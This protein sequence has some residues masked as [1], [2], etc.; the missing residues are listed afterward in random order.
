MKLSAS[1]IHPYIVANIVI[2]SSP[3]WL[4]IA[5]TTLSS[6]VDDVPSEIF[7]S[8]IRRLPSPHILHHLNRWAK[9]V[10][11]PAVSPQSLAELTRTPNR[12]TFIALGFGA[13]SLLAALVHAIRRCNAAAWRDVIAVMFL[14]AD[15]WTVEIGYESV[16][17]DGDVDRA[18]NTMNF[19]YN[20]NQLL[21]DAVSQISSLQ[22]NDEMNTIDQAISSSNTEAFAELR[23]RVAAL[24]LQL[25]DISTTVRRNDRNMKDLL[26][27]FH[28][29]S[30]LLLDELRGYRSAVSDRPGPSKAPTESTNYPNVDGFE[31]LVRGVGPLREN[32]SPLVHISRGRSNSGHHSVGHTTYSYNPSSSP[33]YP[34]SALAAAHT[35]VSQDDS[36]SDAPTGHPSVADGR[37]IASP[38]RPKRIFRDGKWVLL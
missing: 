14:S 4:T 15:P 31:A 34:S 5:L 36:T 1:G 20:Q 11:R 19:L 26:S 12:E 10:W 21:N 32:V 9:H 16:I 8:G 3:A 33:P 6:S 2:M 25:D 17:R 37:P 38:P 30:L 29:W 24:Q 7:Q 18:V 23:C 35:S 13:A 22:Y 28:F 27:S